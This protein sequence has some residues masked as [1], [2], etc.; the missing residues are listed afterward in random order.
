MR[1]DRLLTTLL[2]LQQRSKIT[3]AELA[4]ELEVSVRTA[5][6]DLEA[7]AMSGI[8]IYS[9][10][11]RGGGWQ[12]L[13]GART[14]LTGLTEAE[15]HALFLAIGSSMPTGT[16]PNQI[17]QLPPA[18]PLR[19]AIA[20]LTQA[21]PETF[22]A[23]ATLASAAILADPQGWGREVDSEQPMFLDQLQEALIKQRQ[24][25]LGY[26]K[27][28]SQATVRIIDPLGLIT[29]AGVW[30]LVAGTDAGQRTFRVSR[31]R[32]VELLDNRSVRPNDFDLETH[33]AS[34]TVA[35]QEAKNTTIVTALAEPWTLAPLR[36]IVGTRLTVGESQTQ[37]P[38]AREISEH[39][40]IQ[41][42]T[43]QSQT[44][45]R[46]EVKIAGISPRV[47]AGELAGFGHSLTVISPPSVRAELARIGQELH[48][49]YLSP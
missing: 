33:W 15:T 29:K 6:R 21:L 31:V 18:S 24:V 13:G 40:A 30:Y 41:S 3:A 2:F 14:N 34:I 44:G 9:Q 8:P 12:L 32:S 48:D 1:A 19:V 25:N 22:R 37:E 27:P 11:G 42:Q 26:A 16:S 17:R 4:Q 45:N 39:D 7:L 20:K 47:L 35:V 46:I 36:H 10:P 23:E 43:G 49:T 5:R 38:R 28:G